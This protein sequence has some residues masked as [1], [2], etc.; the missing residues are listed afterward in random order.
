[1]VLLAL[2]LALA[3]WIYDAGRGFAGFDSGESEHKLSELR[4]RVGQLEEEAARLNLLASASESKLQIER[5]AQQELGDQIKRLEADNAR[6]R[7]DVA[8]FEHLVA[9]TKTPGIGIERLQV[10]RGDAP[11][12]YR[13]RMLL[14]APSLPKDKEF[15]GGLQLAVTLMSNGKAVILTIPQVGEGNVPVAFKHFRRVEGMFQ[16]PA[17]AVAKL[18]EARLFQNGILVATQRVSL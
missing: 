12:S 8:V 7:E 2:A 14:I 13:Y 17:E 15:L 6:L 5:T 11:D 16:V 1:V 9:E 10:E 3:G 18:V 4:V